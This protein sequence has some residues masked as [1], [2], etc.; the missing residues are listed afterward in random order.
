MINDVHHRSYPVWSNQRQPII[1]R[2]C[3]LNS[4]FDDLGTDEK[5]YHDCGPS[6]QGS[7]DCKTLMCNVVCVL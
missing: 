4:E 3:E 5:G 2:A 6:L 7:Q 1:V